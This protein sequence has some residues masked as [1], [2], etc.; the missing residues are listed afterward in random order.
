MIKYHEMVIFYR[1]NDGLEC[2]AK[3]IS[4][5]P[6]TTNKP[7]SIDLPTTVKNIWQ[8]PIDPSWSCTARVARFGTFEAKKPNLAFFKLVSLEFFENLY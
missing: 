1:I 4:Q 3:M 2:I 7:Q 5:E 6:A 8:N